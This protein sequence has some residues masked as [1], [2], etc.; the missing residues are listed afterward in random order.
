VPLALETVLEEGAGAHEFQ[1]VQRPDGALTVH[2]GAQ[3]RGRRGPVRAALRRYFDACEVG[4]V[5]ILMSRR[6]PVREPGSGK[7]RRVVCN[8]PR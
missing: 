1:L 2:L 8:L 3:E 7:L 4:P 5:E 6:R